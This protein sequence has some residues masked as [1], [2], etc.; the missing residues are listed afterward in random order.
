MLG[1]QY[2][3]FPNSAKTCLLVKPEFE[4]GAWQLFAGT[5]VEVCVD[6]KRHL[7]TV[8]GS[9]NFTEQ[10]ITTKVQLWTDELLH[11]SDIAQIYPHSAYTAFTYSLIGHRNY[12]FRT[13]LDISHFLQP[14][15]DVINQQFI[16]ALTGRP[17]VS[18]TERNL[19]ACPVCLCGMGLLN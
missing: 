2:G 17:P 6:G 14:L 9:A 18:I 8:L 15:E 3:Y 5:H 19:L 10:Y 1:P 16:P 11:L 12:V 13:V 4:Q 7:G